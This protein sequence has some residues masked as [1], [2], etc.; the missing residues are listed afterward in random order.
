MI[1][2]ISA[3]VPLG[4]IKQARVEIPNVDSRLTINEPTGRFFYDPWKLKPEFVGTVWQNI[5]D[6]LSGPIGEARIIELKEKECYTS[7]SDIDD[8]Y[9]LNIDGQSAYL[10]DLDSQEMFLT[11]PDGAWYIMDAGRRHVA[12][13]FGPK[14]R[15][16]L[17]V[18]KLLNDSTLTDPVSVEIYPAG[19]RRRFNFDDI[20]SPWLNSIDKQHAIREFE[21][22]ETGV[23]FKLE[24]THLDFVK[25]LPQDTF[26][27]VI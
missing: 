20:I 1:K 8:R 22:L 11:E 5:L 4:L 27:I 24:R 19:Y 9:H 25:S 10:I 7:H 18:R 23:R 6:T 2:Q 14:S 21:I 15:F 13:N 3:Y 16:Q 12:A 26:K 17:V